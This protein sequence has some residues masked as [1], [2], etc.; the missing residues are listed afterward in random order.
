MA[1]VKPVIP[2]TITVHL[3]RPDQTAENITVPFSDYVKNVASSEI[4]PTWPENALR[5]NIYAITTFALNRIYTEWYRSR[6]YNFDIT[7]STTVDQAFVK[8]RE[9]FGNISALVDELYNNYVVREGEV[10]PYFTQFCN[11][12]TAT[13]DGLSQ[14]GTVSLAN[15]GY[16]PY[17]ILQYYYGGNINIIRNAPVQNIEESYPGR[18]LKIG[19][20]G[21]GV[22]TIQT[23]LNRIRRNYPAIPRINDPSGIYNI[24]TENAV[25]KFQEI[26]DL[27]VNGEVDKA[28]W[29]RIKKYYVAIKKLGELVGEGLSYNEAQTPFAQDIHYGMR[30]ID[31]SVVQYYLNVISYYNPNLNALPIDGVFGDETLNAVESFQQ[32]YGLPITGVVDRA[33]WNKMVSIYD[34]ILENLPGGYQNEFGK[35]YP[36][37]VIA[38]GARGE[39]VRDVQ[40]F[41]NTISKSIP[42]VPSVTVDGVFGEKTR[43]A[44]ES[45]Q[46]LYGLP[47]NGYVGVVTWYNLVLQ[48]E[49]LIN[50]GQ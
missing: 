44:V 49:Q 19:V 31:V 24:E 36:G 30:G 20:G 35:L 22:A 7:S 11:G 10:Q 37:K 23:Q 6:G 16:T 1:I 18:P 5:A 41:L 4:Y 45:F 3:G 2:E 42:A 26:F 13:C 47:V 14:W 28:T 32:E 29:Y 50:E 8:D 27:P 25:R 46:R 33:T 40:T 48:Y 9:I 34:N 38:Y 39:D 43:A 17:E 12:T 21:N 15:R